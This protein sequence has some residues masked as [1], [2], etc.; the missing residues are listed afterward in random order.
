M[1]Q[2]EISNDGQ[3]KYLKLYSQNREQNKCYNYRIQV[4]KQNWATPQLGDQN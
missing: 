2:S 1:T 4:T 3:E